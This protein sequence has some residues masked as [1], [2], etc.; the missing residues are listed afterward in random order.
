[1]RRVLTTAESHIEE[2]RIVVWKVGWK[3]GWTGRQDRGFSPLFSASE[4]STGENARAYGWGE[5]K[6]NWKQRKIFLQLLVEFVL[7]LKNL[8]EGSVRKN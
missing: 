7:P 6:E 3:V 2:N 4:V 5:E 1:M 8:F